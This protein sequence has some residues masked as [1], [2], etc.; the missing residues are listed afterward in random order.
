VRLH[1]SRRDW[2]WLILLTALVV[3]WRFDKSHPRYKVYGH[4]STPNYDGPALEDTSTG[5]MWPLGKS[6]K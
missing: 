1:F 3:G 6:L 4:L 2:F 5:E